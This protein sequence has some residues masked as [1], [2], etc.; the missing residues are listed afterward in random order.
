MPYTDVFVS[1]DQRAGRKDTTADS[2]PTVLSWSR[3]NMIVPM[4]GSRRALFTATEWQAQMFGHRMITLNKT[5]QK[6]ICECTARVHMQHHFNC[7]VLLCCILQVFY[8]FHLLIDALFWL[9]VCYYVIAGFNFLQDN[10]IMYGQKF[11]RQF[12]KMFSTL[13]ELIVVLAD[14]VHMV[15]CRAVWRDY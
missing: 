1:W 4:L 7:F 6:K 14:L 10:Y 3:S 11:W 13:L 2:P 5:W 15:A 8:W 9:L 12:V